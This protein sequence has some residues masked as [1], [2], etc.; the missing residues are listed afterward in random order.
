[1]NTTQTKY[2]L[3]ANGNETK[4]F[5]TYE[6]AYTFGMQWKSTFSIFSEIAIYKNGELME[7]M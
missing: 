3:L 2:T 7:N 5:K 4:P 1:M 6:E